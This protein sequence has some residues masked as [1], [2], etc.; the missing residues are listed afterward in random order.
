MS[1]FN[2][3]GVIKH[4][5]YFDYTGDKLAELIRVALISDGLDLTIPEVMILQRHYT[6]TVQNTF[7]SYILRRQAEKRAIAK[8]LCGQCKFYLPIDE[9]CPHKERTALTDSCDIFR[10]KNPDRREIDKSI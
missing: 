7:S 6:M 10:Y 9:K 1:I 4:N 5:S 3:F 2:E 8:P